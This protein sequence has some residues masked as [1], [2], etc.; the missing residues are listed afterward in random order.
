MST[1][2]GCTKNTGQIVLGGHTLTK[3]V[4]SCCLCVCLYAVPSDGG[5]VV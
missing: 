2:F 5:S 4:F 1:A 3:G